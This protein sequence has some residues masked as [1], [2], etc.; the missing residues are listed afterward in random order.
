MEKKNHQLK[1]NLWKMNH[2]QSCF[3]YDYA[4]KTIL[5]SYHHL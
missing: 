2:F 1:M 5:V 3:M 4:L